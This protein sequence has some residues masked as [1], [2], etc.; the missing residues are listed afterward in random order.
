[1][2]LTLISAILCAAVLPAFAVEQADIVVNYAYIAAVTKGN[3]LSTAHTLQVTVEAL[4]TSPS[5][6]THAAAKD[7]SLASR[8]SY[9]QS[10]AF[11]CGN[12]IVEDWDSRVNAWP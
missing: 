2:K 10:E 1:M 4:I 8:V 3:S 5:I 11:R 9:Q 12:P 6:K 7:A